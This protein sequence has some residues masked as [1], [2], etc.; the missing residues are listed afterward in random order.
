MK[1]VAEHIFGWNLLGATFG[2]ILEYSSM[3]LGYN[4]LSLMVVGLYTVVLLLLRIA[5]A[6]SEIEESGQT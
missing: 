5:R 4:A 2:G 1:Q 3:A 6:R